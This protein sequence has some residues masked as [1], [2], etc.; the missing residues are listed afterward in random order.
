[1]S[2]S[3]YWSCGCSLRPSWGRQSHSEFQH[4]SGFSDDNDLQRCGDFGSND[5]FQRV[6]YSS[7]MHSRVGP[8]FAVRVRIAY[9]AY[10]LP[11]KAYATSW[12]LKLKF[13]FRTY[14]NTLRHKKSLRYC[15]VALS[16]DSSEE[17]QCCRNSP[18]KLSE[19]ARHVQYL[20][21][22]RLLWKK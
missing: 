16:I 10:R 1:M 17:N 4:I 14:M 6:M 11:I 21:L 2:Y 22:K 20:R 18:L 8:S 13:S 5:Q 19:Y 7:H 3:Y 12:F 15:S 9:R